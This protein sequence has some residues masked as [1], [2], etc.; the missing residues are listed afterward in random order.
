[1]IIEFNFCTYTD[2]PTIS[3]QP[4]I[5]MS[6]SKSRVKT[7]FNV[8]GSPNPSLKIDQQARKIVNSSVEIDENC[9]YFV[10]HKDN[11]GGNITVTAE[12]CFGQSS[13]TI[14]VS[15]FQS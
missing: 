13:V 5:I 12:N 6:E 8:T 14:S 4:T 3:E 9:V 10:P 1:M 2:L 11:N 7:C 15:N